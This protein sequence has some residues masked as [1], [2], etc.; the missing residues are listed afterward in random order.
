[1]LMVDKR[2]Y[3]SR[4]IGFYPESV[5]TKLEDR[6]FLEDSIFVVFVKKV[7]Y[8]ESI[9][10]KHDQ[11]ALLLIKK[12]E[13]HEYYYY[14]FQC[15]KIG[16]YPLVLGFYKDDGLFSVYKKCVISI[17]NSIFHKKNITFENI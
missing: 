10:L 2:E 8:K 9:F 12:L 17:N 13:D 14:V 5:M 16:H 6:S 11:R 15:K 3:L 7:S 1:M 4:L